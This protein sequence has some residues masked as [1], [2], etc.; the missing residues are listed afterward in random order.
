[1][2][3]EKTEMLMELQ[4]QVDDFQHRIGQ[5][6]EYITELNQML[7]IYGKELERGTSVT[8]NSDLLRIATDNIL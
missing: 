6:E 3:K 4:A 1:M 2:L 5:R 8:F 7:K